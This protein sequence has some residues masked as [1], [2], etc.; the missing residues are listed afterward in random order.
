MEHKEEKRNC[1]NCKKDFTIEPDD[2]SFYEKMRVCA[3]DTCPDCRA[4]LRLSFRNE[5]AFYKRACDKCGK[6][7]VSMY[8]PNKSFK[9]WC[10]DCWFSDNWGGEDF[11]IEYD[12]DIPFFEQYEKLWRS[13]P[14][15]SLIYMRSP[16]SEYTNISADNKNCYFIIESSNNEDSI[17]SYWIQ[18]CRDVVDTSFASKCELTYESDDCYNSYKLLYSKGCHDCTTSYFLTDCKGCTDCIGC[19]NLRNKSNYIFNESYSKEEYE[20]IKKDLMLDTYSGVKMFKEKYEDF[21]K[22][23]PRK[24]AEVMQV[25]NSTGSYMKNT[26]NCQS[27][28]HCYDAEDNKYG[29]HIWR[30]AKDTMDC[31]TAGRNVSRI[32]NSI[33]AGIDNSNLVCDALCWT[34]SFVEYSMYCFNSNNCFGCVGMRKKNYCI[35]N[36]QY[37]KEEYEE[38][39]SKIKS[40]LKDKGE[41]GQFFG[42]HLSCFGYNETPAN[43]Q[44]PLSKDEAIK[45]GSRWEDTERGTYNKETKKVDQ[46]PESFS[47]IDFDVAKE[48]FICESC[49][50]NYRVIPNEFLFYKK[51]N[52]PLPRL[53]PDCRHY[54]RM[55]SRGPN[56]LWYRSC[57]KEGCTNEFETSYA[58]YRPEIVYCEKCYQNEVI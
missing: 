27:C 49:N 9:V 51:L 50:K 3:P 24:F 43:E 1:Q 40:E 18:E 22:K 37:E 58:P 36:K 28:F 32:Y 35:L 20:Q 46:M 19:I 25:V 45:Q 55:K 17:H 30:N 10:Y 38:I 41:Y 42:K 4:Q 26:K 13:V 8:S 57:M 29:V 39:V 31:D 5:R 23:Q 48:V 44:F 54:R 21:L 11:G 52:V 53:C 15:V 14:K 6:D 34:C 47:E 7:V 12:K 56:K 16:G 2:F 33:N